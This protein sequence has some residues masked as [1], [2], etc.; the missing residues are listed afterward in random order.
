MH[1]YAKCSHTNKKKYILKIQTLAEFV[2]D[3]KDYPEEPQSS[4]SLDLLSAV[5]SFACLQYLP[6]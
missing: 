4:P 2:I 6:G 3:F 5:S 1:A